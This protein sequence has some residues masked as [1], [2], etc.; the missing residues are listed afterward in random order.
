MNIEE[1]L[2]KWKSESIFGER[3][4][5]KLDHTLV[6]EQ[7][8]YLISYNAKV[9]VGGEDKTIEKNDFSYIRCDRTD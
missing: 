7:L 6:E 3:Q 8:L 9:S 1:Y 2:S 4:F 5:K